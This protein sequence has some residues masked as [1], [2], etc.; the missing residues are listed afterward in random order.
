M[1]GAAVLL[2]VSLLGCGEPEP[3]PAAQESAPAPREPLGEI[4]V[5]R[6][7][8]ASVVDGPPFNA[9]LARFEGR[10]GIVNDCLVFDTGAE[11]PYLPVFEPET[12]IA[13]F[14]DR[15]VIGGQTTLFDTRITRAGGVEPDG[16]E[17]RLAEPPP[18][19]C[20][21]ALIAR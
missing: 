11:R 19:E 17:A 7:A 6:G 12:D 13:V 14:A 20:P 4:Y 1:R 8:S 21:Y 16:A 3:T 15:V 10:Y 9:R 5:A 2:C 18:P